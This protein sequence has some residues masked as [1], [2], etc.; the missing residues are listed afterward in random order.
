MQKICRYSCIICRIN[1]FTS[2]NNRFPKQKEE[3]KK[4]ETPV[5]KVHNVLYPNDKEHNGYKVKRKTKH[6]RKY[7]KKVN[8]MDRT[9]KI[10]TKKVGD[11][12][13]KVTVSPTK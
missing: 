13:K 3:V 4:T 8:T 1:C 7:V 5:Q 9:T 12:D 6:G 11:M 10:K 2:S